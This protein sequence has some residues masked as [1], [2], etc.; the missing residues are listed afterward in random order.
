MLAAAPDVGDVGDVDLLRGI[1]K[2]AQPLDLAAVEETVPVH[3]RHDLRVVGVA[4]PAVRLEVDVA[5]GERFGIPDLPT[6]V[7]VD[8]EPDPA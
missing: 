5:P 8:R 3:D 2:S 4:G 1:A 6:I 7:A